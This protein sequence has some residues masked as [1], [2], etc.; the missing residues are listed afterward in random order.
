MKKLIRVAAI[1]EIIALFSMA[2]SANA[3][4]GEMGVGT[5]LFGVYSAAIV[6]PP[7]TL[8]WELAN[9]TRGFPA[10]CSRLT[11]N[12]GTM[13]MDTY[14]IALAIMMQARAMNTRVK[15]YAHSELN[16]GCGVDFVEPQP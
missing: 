9:A 11:L 12:S 16:G 7:E 5:P 4:M 15:F 2:S 10:G 1:L 14:K 8:V 6:N 3:A 13:G